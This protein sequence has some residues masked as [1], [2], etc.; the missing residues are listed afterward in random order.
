[1][2]LQQKKMP[3]TF[4]FGSITIMDCCFFW[5]VQESFYSSELFNLK[6]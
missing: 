4:V 3:D 1:M 5:K 6:E 2:T